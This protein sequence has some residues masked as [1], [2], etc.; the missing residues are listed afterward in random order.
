[1]NH[2]PPRSGQRVHVSTPRLP[3]KEAD[4]GDRNLGVTR[5][6][7]WVLRCF[8]VLLSALGGYSFPPGRLH[9]FEGAAA[10]VLFAAGIIA[11]ELALRRALLRNLIGSLSGVV[12][13]LVVAF[14]AVSVL[15]RTSL[16]VSTR[17]LVCL[18]FVLGAAYT[19][20][21]VGG[22]KGD[23]LN[24]QALGGIF[25]PEQIVPRTR[26]LLDT[27][28]IIDGRIGDIAEAHFLD[29]ILIVP[30]FV[31]RE[32]QTVAD[33]ADSVKRQRGRRGLEVLHRIQKMPHV[34]VQFVEEEFPEIAEV[35]LKLIEAARRYQAKLMTNDF[36]LN[37]VATLQG[38]E[39]LNINQLANALK[40][41]VLAGETMRVL[42]LREGKEFNQGV[43]YLDDGTMVVVD[44]ARK[45]INHSIEI[46]VT[47][48]HQT[49]AGKMIFGRHDNRGD[50]APQTAT[51]LSAAVGASERGSS[52][53]RRSKRPLREPPDSS[54]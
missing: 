39:I 3:R 9:P 46:T 22:K 43:A 35:D 36:N 42:I 33:S 27:S 48:V 10:G 18:L 13:G 40:P 37:K 12:A 29:G 21:I 15:S 24:L 19:G 51:S 25:R 32:L 54:S 50:H 49:T 2:E 34:H 5:L 31:L 45:Y 20:F 26:K 28:V 1:M 23:L 16:S 7:V 17:S 30:R 38:V 11:T 53:E 6:S 41:L 47:S 52:H 14:L 44:G 4:F 8:L